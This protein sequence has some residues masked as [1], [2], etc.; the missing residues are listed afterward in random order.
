VAT[1]RPEPGERSMRRLLDSLDTP[2]IFAVLC[3]CGVGLMAIASATL[4]QPGREHLWKMQLLWILIAGVA[5]T[6]VV[7]IDYH[8]WSGIG[9]ML[10]GAVVALLVAVLFFG[11]TVGGNKSWLVFGPIRLQPSELAKWT[12]CLVVAGYLAHRHKKKLGLRELLE[13]GLLIGVPMGLIVLQ[14]DHGTALIFIPV[15]LA[16]IWLGGLRWK[17]IAWILVI[18]LALAP[19]IWTQLKPYQRNRILN[20]LDQDRDPTGVG[21]QV[22][23]SKIAIGSGGLA[24]KGVFSGTQSQLNY[25]PAQHTDFIFAVISE[26]LGFLGSGGVLALFYFLL[27]RGVAG[28]VTAQDRMGTYLCLLVVSWIAGQMAINVGTVLGL[29]PT[30][31]VPLPLL[32]Y[33]GSALVATLCGIGLII[34]VRTRRFVN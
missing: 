12:T 33:G 3:L 9:M 23:Q 24:G 5:A 28:A 18:G 17:I 29:L 11:R 13:I 25:L 10:H 2:T 15:F 19:V 22:R 26:E 21:Y 27:Y 32:S 31:G 6:I 34:N 4:K 1:C 30:I 8:V 14:P 7:M 20:V 16:A